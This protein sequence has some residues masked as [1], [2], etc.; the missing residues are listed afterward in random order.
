MGT[1][2]EAGARERR[3]WGAA[4]SGRGGGGDGAQRRCRGGGRARERGM[5]GGH[6]RGKGRARPRRAGKRT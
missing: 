6:C 5:T 2:V 4:V 3:C 1:A